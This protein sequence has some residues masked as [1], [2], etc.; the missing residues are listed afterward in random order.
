MLPDLPG[1]KRDI[2]RLLDRYLQTQVDARIGVF[3]ESPKHTIHEGNRMRTVRGNGSIDE[4]ELKEA[5]AN[6]SLNFDDVPRLT[7]EEQLTKINDIADQM[8]RQISEHLFGTL[9]AILDKVGQVVDQKGRPLDAE[10]IFA[11][12][13]KLQLDF[14]EGGK[15]NEISIVML[16]ALAPKVKQVFEQIMSEPLLRQRYEEIIMRKRMEW[17]DREAARKL[18]G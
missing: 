11:V 3:K 2:Q 4:S 17:R 1:L 18:V 10:G 5:S 7:L 8:A 14:D 13:E 16:P 12:L 9:N 6:M 15:H